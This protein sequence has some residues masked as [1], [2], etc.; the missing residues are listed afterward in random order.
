MLNKWKKTVY[1]RQ[2]FGTLLTDLF[3]PFDCLNHGLLLRLLVGYLKKRKQRTKL[4]S[5][6]SPWV[7]LNKVS[8]KGLY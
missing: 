6:N 8:I 7:M 5:S 4:E 2:A 1:N 3:K